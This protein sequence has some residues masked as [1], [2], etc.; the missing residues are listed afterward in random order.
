MRSVLPALLQLVL[1][2]LQNLVLLPELASCI[3]DVFV[4]LWLTNLVLMQ[5]I[6]LL[7]QLLK[8]CLMLLTALN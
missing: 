2:G 7:L 6:P 8:R 4:E 5:D 1:E 3:I